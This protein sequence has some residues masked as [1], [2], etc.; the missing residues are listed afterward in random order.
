MLFNYS[1]STSPGSR[2]IATIEVTETFTVPLHPVPYG[3]GGFILMLNKPD[4]MPPGV[5]MCEFYLP[6]GDDDVDLMGCPT[7]VID[8]KIV[9][10][11]HAR[12]GE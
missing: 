10:I 11:Y 7:W 2:L 1:E 6:R 5:L 4:E 3:Y 12:S 8:D 9:I